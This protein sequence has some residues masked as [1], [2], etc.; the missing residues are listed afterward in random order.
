MNLHRN[1]GEKNIKEVID[2]HP[3]IGAILDRFEIGCIKCTVGTCLLKDVVAVHFL[4]DEIEA[5][6]EE[7]I[8][9]YLD[10]I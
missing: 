6:I 10:N 8:N 3:P 7:E 9:R 5:S 2:A 4:G 1:M